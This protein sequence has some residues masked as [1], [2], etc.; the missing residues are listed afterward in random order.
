MRNTEMFL[1]NESQ[2]NMTK[3]NKITPIMS[4]IGNRISNN[5]K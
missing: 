2:I 5:I 3:S 4:P 1:N